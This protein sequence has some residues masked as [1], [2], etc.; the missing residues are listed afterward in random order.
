MVKYGKIDLKVKYSERR[1]NMKKLLGFLLGTA[2]S[3][4]MFAE[5]W[6]MLRLTR[7]QCLK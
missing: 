2:F 3:I 7:R 1:S 6:C 5:F 4:H